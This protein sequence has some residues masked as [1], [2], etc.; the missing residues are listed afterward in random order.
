MRGEPPAPGDA[1]APKHVIRL[2]G[3]WLWA[4]EDGSAGKSD[5]GK[6]ASAPPWPTGLAVTLTRHFGHPPVGT[7]ESLA[8]RILAARGIDGVTLDDTPTDATLVPVAGGPGS[9]HRLDIAFVPTADRPGVP[10]DAV[11]LHVFDKQASGGR[12]PSGR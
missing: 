10:F 1:P 6:A 2:R 11:E 5:I 3:P 7:D 9:R 12:Q 8:V 4:S